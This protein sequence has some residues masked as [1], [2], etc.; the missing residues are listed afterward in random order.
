MHVVSER[1]N[2]NIVMVMDWY[3]PNNYDT[4]GLWKVDK[5]ASL[6]WI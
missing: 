5:C 4:T 1:R 2:S 6:S 3:E